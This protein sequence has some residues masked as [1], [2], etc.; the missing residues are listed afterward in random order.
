MKNEYEYD[1]TIT[2][3]KLTRP[4]PYIEL[5]VV[6][7]TL[8]TSNVA[9]YFTLASSHYRQLQQ[10]AEDIFVAGSD[11]SSP[12]SHVLSRCKYIISTSFPP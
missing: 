4:A 2:S 6:D 11:H 5:V 7:E 3:I 12:I 1:R 10:H 9:H 8:M